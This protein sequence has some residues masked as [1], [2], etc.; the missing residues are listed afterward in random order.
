MTSHNTTNRFR[1]AI[2][3]ALVCI[4]LFPSVARGD[5]RDIQTALTNA[6]INVSRLSVVEA[7][8][9]MIIRGSVQR[10]D[11]IELVANVVRGLGYTRVAPL[12]SVVPIP[13]DD[14]IA[15]AAERQLSRNRSLEGCQLS[16]GSTNGVVTIRGTVGS[17]L[18]GDL[19]RQIVGRV[20]GVK[21]VRVQLLQM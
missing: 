12:L 3:A 5:Q 16:V 1:V 15:L 19:A 13:D 9:I 14:A 8:G 17:A 7:E 10:R 21:E 11:Q 6:Q 2:M 18:Q 4:V 20:E